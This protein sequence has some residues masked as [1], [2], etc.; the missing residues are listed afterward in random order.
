MSPFL[1]WKYWKIGTNLS[2]A[3]YLVQFAVFHYN[4]GKVRGS[5]PFSF[6]GSIVS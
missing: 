1:N 4:N 5:T 3:I 6:Y 2:Y